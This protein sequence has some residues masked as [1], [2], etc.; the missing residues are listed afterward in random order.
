MFLAVLRNQLL[1][2]SV[3]VCRSMRNYTPRY[4]LLLLLA[5]NLALLASERVG[6]QEKPSSSTL[7]TTTRAVIVNAVVT[8]RRGKP[9]TDLTG[10]DF[11]IFDNGHPETLGS[12]LPTTSEQVTPSTSFEGPDIYKNIPA[13]PTTG[14]SILLFDTLNSRWTSQVYALDRIRKF[15]RH[16][17]P[18]DHL[19]IYVLGQDLEVVHEFTRDASDLVAGIQRYDKLHS[20]APANNNPAQSKKSMGVLEHF[21]AG[22]D[23]CIC[24]P[25]YDLG[26]MTT[27]SLETI[28]R[29][30]SSLPGRK[31]LIWVTDGASVLL[32]DWLHV[33]PG[34][35]SSDR[36]DIE[37]L[38]RLMNSAAIAVYPIEAKGLDLKDGIFEGM[39]M[40]KLA[41]RTGG[42]AFFNRND[43][44]TGIR[45]AVD[46]SRYSYELTYYPQHNQWNGKWRELK[47]KVDRPDV[48]VLARGGYLALPD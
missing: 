11:T 9:I 36:L 12:F 31:T 22:S 5:A 10:R 17:E 14:V 44:E 19:G 47:V 2:T 38:I 35:P 1:L 29:Q 7:R 33:W 43:L 15:L 20:H 32:P 26:R 23:N 30:I 21:L 8:D 37:R 40:A 42:R 25:R 48:N 46:D 34:L 16:I 45:R 28:A 39:V 24:F 13:G 6:A 18:R 3:K 41:S 4:R 27:V